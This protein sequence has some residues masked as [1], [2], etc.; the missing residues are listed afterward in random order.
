MKV[1]A[2]KKLVFAVF[3]VVSILT[4]AE[5]L[6][7]LAGVRP[8]LYDEDPYVGF[9]SHIPL[10][11][12]ETSSDGGAIMVTADNKLSLF[13]SQRFVREKADGTRRIFC[14]GGSTTFG[15]PYDD[16][17]SFCGWL[18]EMLPEADPDH[19]WELINAGGVSYASYRVAALIEELI[20]YE[21]DLFIIYSGHNEFL[22]RR[23]YGRIM[24]TPRALRSL[25]AIVSRTRLYAAVGRAIGK[26]GRR[27]KEEEGKR[28]YLPGEV[29]TILERSLGPQEYHRDDE[30]RPRVFDHYRYNLSRMIDIARSV[31]ANVILVTPAANLRHCRPFKSEHGDGLDDADREN[32]KALYDEA[33]DARAEGRW[34]EALAAIDRALAI[35]ERHADAHYLRGRVLWELGSFDRAKTA[36]E[37]AMDEDVCPL[38]ALKPLQDIVVEVG[39]LKDVA[40]VD[41]AAMVEGMSE[42]GTPGEEQFLDHAHPTIEGNRQLAVA[43]LETMSRQQMV[44]LAGTWGDAEIKLIKQRVESRLDLMAHGAALR[45]VSR[46]YRWAGR[47]EEGYKLGLRATEMF[48]TDAEAF[49]QVA[50]NAVELGRV[51]EAIEHYRLA[52]QIEP[53]YARAHCGLAIALELHRDAPNPG[54][55]DAASDHYV[56]AL[57]IKPDYPEAHSGLGR[58]LAAQDR[59]AEAIWHYRQAISLEPDLVQAHGGLG[60]ALHMQ[61][62]LDEAIGHYRRA[63]EIDPDHPEAHSSLASALA[64]QGKFDEAVNHYRRAL[65]TRPGYAEVHYRLGRTLVMAGEFD[66]ALKHFRRAAKLKPDWPEP[67]NGIAQILVIHPDA[68]VRDADEAVSLAER[69]AT[70]TEHKDAWVLDTLAVAYGAA[71]QFDRAVATTQTALEL[72]SAAG[73]AELADYLVRQLEVYRNSQAET[74]K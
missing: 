64:E 36:F 63:I 53:N 28:T 22:E 56:R 65:R 72:A 39:D 70:L 18:R 30:L 38:R 25:G 43:L 50:A 13:N 40:V 15:R 59:L 58:T 24:D 49:F 55:L 17:T 21:P 52:L 14:M 41:F 3:T 12:E 66:D 7:A 48:P 37:R 46:L 33:S 27:P 8:A 31:G 1:S 29:K 11:V 32:F 47:F 68:G 71:G 6:L 23:T 74:E 62:K 19:T 10:F 57:E 51:D 44:K 35:D 69:A 42:H 4:A 54:A 34:G 67:L 20:R 5:V 26:A 73:A 61:G 45:N 9:S 60:I 2:T 16:M